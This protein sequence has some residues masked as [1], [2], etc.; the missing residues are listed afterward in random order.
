MYVE[1][2]TTKEGPATKF[3]FDVLQGSNAIFQSVAEG[4]GRRFVDLNDLT[5]KQVGELQRHFSYG[6]EYRGEM[7]RAVSELCL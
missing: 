3:V 2:I 7:S 6:K 5:S 1:E 4:S